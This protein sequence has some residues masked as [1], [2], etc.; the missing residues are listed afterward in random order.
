MKQEADHNKIINKVAGGVLKPMGLFRKGQSRIWIDDNDWFLI[1]VEFQPSN[2]DKG[3]YLNVA[4]NYLWS[5]KEYL[6]FDYGHRESAF[7]RCGNDE[8]LFYDGICA[9]AEKAAEKVKEYREFRDID[10]AKEKIIQKKDTAS[11]S[12]E[13]YHKMMVCGLAKDI[14]AFEFYKKLTDEVKCSALSYEVEYY[15]ELTGE[16]FKVIDDADKFQEYILQKINL[17]R[18][19]WRSKSSMKK[20]KERIEFEG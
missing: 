19:F 13:L 14:R 6:S 3:S 1:I 18:E 4:V 10:Y 17:Q 15:R 12:H 9:L 16:V 5:G 11:R 7:V 2:W 8:K 20:L